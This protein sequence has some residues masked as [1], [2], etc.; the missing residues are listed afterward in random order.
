VR[1]RGLWKTA[2]NTA[3]GQQSVLSSSGSLE[4]CFAA[5]TAMQ[6]RSCNSRGF[7]GYIADVVNFRGVNG[8]QIHGTAGNNCAPQRKQHAMSRAELLHL[9]SPILFVVSSM[10]YGRGPVANEAPLLLVRFLAVRPTAC[11][12]SPTPGL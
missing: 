4:W 8:A 11:L 6:P 2:G 1:G 3:A 12:P 7:D 10:L 9:P 5:C